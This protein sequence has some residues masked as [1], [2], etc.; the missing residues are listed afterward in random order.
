[1]DKIIVQFVVPDQS[2]CAYY[3]LQQVMFQLMCNYRSRIAATHAFPQTLVS[4]GQSVVY[5]QRVLTA[6]WFEAL[7]EW[8]AKTNVKVIIDYDDIMW[9][10][11]L[12][13][14]NRAI[15]HERVADRHAAMSKYLH[16]VADVVTCST[17]FLAQNLRKYHHDVRVFPNCL[18]YSVW[19]FQGRPLSKT[20]KMLYAGSPTHY[21]NFSKQYGDLEIGLV[22]FVKQYGVK[23]MGSQPP[24]FFEDI[25]RVP[26]ATANTYSKELFRN[27]ADCDFV[28]SP[29]APN[30]FNR[31]KSDL[32]Y[33]EA[34]AVGRVC[35][36]SD[37]DGSPYANAHPLQKIPYKVGIKDMERIVKNCHEHYT[38]ILKYQYEYLQKRWLDDLM[39]K[40][41]ALFEEVAG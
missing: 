18:S 14:Y 11:G 37:F 34:A 16:E 15:Y 3:R 27:T 28:I 1:M 6:Q 20:H 36:V 31:A 21:D 19:G 25:E 41:E 30:D 23:F 9:E 22:N 8:K 40:Y 4:N 24:W 13:Q 39:P 5:L 33:L 2:A 26:W 29:L 32:K 12:P 38:E 17:E 35:L 7:Q 10:D